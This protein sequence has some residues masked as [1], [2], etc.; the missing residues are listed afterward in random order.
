MNYYCIMVKTGAEE[1]FKKEA[2]EKGSSFAVGLQFYF[3]KRKVINGGK[4]KG[5]IVE[6]PMFPGYIFMGCA[7]IDSYLIEQIRSCK[8]FYR[9]LSSDGKIRP[10]T[11]Q[12]LDYLERLMRHGEVAGFSRVTFD[13]N[14]RIVIL[15]GP[16]EGFK[17]NI[18]KVDRRKRRV[19]IRLDM[20]GSINKVDL[21][22][23]DVSKL[24][25]PSAS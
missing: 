15:D 13:E 14:D 9:F 8:N 18:I 6:S 2:L 22:Y 3:F 25:G 12:D 4:Q 5:K 11:G 7:D 1:S 19:T 16:L 17:G 20:C 23:E 24:S 10:L 21:C